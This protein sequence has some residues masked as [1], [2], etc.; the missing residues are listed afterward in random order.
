MK[1]QQRIWAPAVA[2]T[3]VATVNIQPPYTATI[4]DTTGTVAVDTWVHIAL[5]RQGTDLKMYRAGTRVA[6]VTNSQTWDF[7]DATDGMRIG[8]SRWSGSAEN[9]DG[10]IQD[11]RLTKGLCRYT[12]ADETSN[13]PTAPL[14]G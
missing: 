2:G 14:E 12:A 11:L 9:F 4:V 1:K 3:M 7:S 10:Y 8:Q 13:I 6:T 5:C